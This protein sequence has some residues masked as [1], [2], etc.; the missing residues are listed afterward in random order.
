MIY[1]LRVLLEYLKDAFLYRMRGGGYVTLGDTLA[2]AIWVTLGLGVSYGDL[3]WG[4]I[5]LIVLIWIMI[6]GFLALV[7]IPHAFAQNMGRFGRPWTL[8]ADGTTFSISKY[9]PGAWLPYIKTQA[10]WNAATAAKK[11]WLDYC[12]MTSC[13]FLRGTVVYG[14][15]MYFSPIRAALAILTLTILQPLGY[16]L[17]PH[18]PFSLPGVAAGTTEWAEWLNGAAWA[19]SV[20]VAT[21]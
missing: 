9:W 20:T 11:F 2:R 1:A 8:A 13:A 14:P 19:A 21:I 6:G 16:A 5:N 18:I 3:A 10:D 15:L 4:H 7:L 17:A 12:G